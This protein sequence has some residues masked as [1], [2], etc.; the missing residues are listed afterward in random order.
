MVQSRQAVADP[1]DPCEVGVRLGDDGRGTRVGEDPLD[2]LRGR[3]VVDRDGYRAGEPDGVV[4]ECPLV[5]GLREQPDP[6]ALADPGGDEAL[7]DTRTSSRNWTA[8]TS[9]QP[10]PALRLNDT[11]SGYSVALKTMSSV[12]FPVWGISM[13]KGVVY[14]RTRFS[15]GRQHQHVA[16]YRRDHLGS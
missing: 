12:R 7:G 4:E 14:S 10:L 13:V 2:L 5:A 8:V 6:V 16:R 9:A 11:V 3:A 1:G 15:S